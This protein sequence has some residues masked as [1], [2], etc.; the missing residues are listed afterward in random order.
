MQLG[1]F[2]AGTLLAETNFRTQIEADIRPFRGLLLGLFFVTTGTS[3]D[4]QLLLREWPN[5]LSLFEARG[6]KAMQLL[7]IGLKVKEYQLLRRNFSDTGCLVLVF[8]STL[9]SHI[10]LGI[11]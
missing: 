11:K 2:L 6:D 7:E 4:T 9:I 1:V 8:R 3:I 5:V 10:D